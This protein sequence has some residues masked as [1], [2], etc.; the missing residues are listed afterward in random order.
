MDFVGPCPVRLDGGLDSGVPQAFEGR[1]LSIESETIGCLC[2]PDP[3][4]LGNSIP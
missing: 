3:P 4:V 2:S 1:C